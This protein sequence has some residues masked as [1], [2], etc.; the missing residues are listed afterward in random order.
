MNT[1]SFRA[2][3]IDDVLRLNRTMQLVQKPVY[4]RIHTDFR[5]PDVVVEMDTDVSPDEVVIYMGEQEDSHVMIETFKATPIADN[6]MERTYTGRP[7]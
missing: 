5:L 6:P 2:E 1:Y 3:C 7:A 4:L